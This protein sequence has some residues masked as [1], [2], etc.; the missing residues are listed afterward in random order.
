MARR[1]P[2]TARLLAGASLALIGAMMAGSALAA[3]SSA[4]NTGAGAE[5]T[6][7]ESV[8]VTAERAPGAKYA[9]VKASLD[10]VQPESIVSHNFIEQITPETGNISTV[11]FI[12]PSVSGI[13]GN[14]GGIGNYF[15]T[16]MRG[17]SDGEYN[18]TFDGIAFGDTNNPTHHPNDYFPTSTI[19]AAVVDRGPGAAGDLGQANY[20]GAIHYFSP[21]VSDHFGVVQKLTYGSFNTFAGVT[22]INTGEIPQLGGGKLWINLDERASDTELSHSGG[23]TY[24]QTAKFVLP[25]TNKLTFTAFVEHAW[26]RYNFPD[27]GGPGETVAQIDA[28]GKDF[29]LTNIPGDEH[30]Y[31]WNY[32]RKQTF[33]NYVDLK[34][35]ATQNITVE[36]EPYQYFYSNKTYSTDDNSGLIAYYAPGGQLVGT[37]GNL[38]SNIGTSQAAIDNAAKING[39]TNPNA[40]KQNANDIYGYFK[41]ND[42]NVYGNVLR[43]TDEL[44]FG[45]LKVGGLVE[46]SNTYRQKAFYDFDN[47]TPVYLYTFGAGP[48]TGQ[49]TNYKLEENSS[50][51]QE[52]VFVDFNWTPTSALTISPGFKYVNFQRTVAGAVEAYPNKTI[53]P[54]Y[55]TNTYNSPLY[56]FTTNYKIFPFWS[57]YGQFA[58]SFL[59]P[60]LAELEVPGVTLQSLKPQTTNNYQAGT[61]FSRGPITADVDGYVI[62]SFNTNMPCEITDPATNEVQQASCNIGNVRYSGVEGEAAYTLPFGLTFFANGSINDAKQSAQAKNAATGASAT[63][64]QEVAGVPKWTDAA[65]ILFAHGPWHASLSYKQVG[66]QAVYTSKTDH[67]YVVPSYDTWNASAA[68]DFK[69]FEIKVQAFN[70]L[71]KRALINYAPTKSYSGGLYSPSDSGG[72]YTFQSG[73]EL[74]LTLVAKY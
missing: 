42:Y 40:G 28:Y 25:L 8:I 69:N 74:Q 33:F 39:A 31:K 2:L 45:V 38:T 13:S 24:N 53:G 16:T 58:T 9:P 48:N 30:W 20:G 26:S 11:I 49:L 44:P 70:L 61:V 17:F 35:Q 50:W 73:R 71:D 54:A 52:Q 5:G 37:A 7:V 12:A 62:D 23:D 32:E 15:S 36:D 21:A 4:Q 34:Y 47:N 1:N 27:S 14:G 43:F 57:V 3:E 6:E 51:V 63:P 60:Q 59:I 64:A 29:Q 46:G 66:D 22:T 18:V 10:Q 41:R 65:G 55:G 68:Y 67:R 56:F 19:G 72:F